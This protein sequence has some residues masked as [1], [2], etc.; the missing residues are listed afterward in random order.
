MIVSDVK[1]GQKSHW[2]R[3]LRVDEIQ[4]GGI[5]FVSCSMGGGYLLSTDFNNRIPEAVR[6]ASGAY[7][8]TCEWAIP[9]LVFPDLFSEDEKTQAAKTLS[10]M[11]PKAWKALNGERVSDEIEARF[12]AI[13]TENESHGDQR[14]ACD[15]IDCALTKAKNALLAMD[16]GSREDPETCMKSLLVNL[17]HLSAHLGLNFEK[18]LESARSRLT[19]ESR[20][21][22]GY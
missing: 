18:T 21:C 6:T 7:E 17:M 4:A 22:D 13:G 10:S 19:A 3:I 2:G 14:L 11:Y 1:E 16:K 12:L 8:E 9:V 15:R 5:V 20:G